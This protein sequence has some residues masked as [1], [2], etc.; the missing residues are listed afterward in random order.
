LRPKNILLGKGCVKIADFGM[1][2]P[3]NN[4]NVKL[5]LMQFISSRYY[6]APEGLVPNNVYTSAVDVWAVGCIMAEMILG[7]V[8]FKDARCLDQMKVVVNTLGHFT[9]EDM[10]SIAHGINEKF[11]V[12]LRTLQPTSNKQLKDFFPDLDE[13]GFDLLSQMLTF[14]PTKRIT[15]EKALQHA[16]FV[17][18]VQTSN[19]HQNV[20]A[21]SQP[22]SHNQIPTQ[23]ET[24]NE[25][26]MDDPETK[27]ETETET[28]TEL[29]TEFNGDDIENVSSLDDIRELLWKE[30]EALHCQDKKIN[31]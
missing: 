27:N 8:F 19:F 4:K 12:Y 30:V 20:I 14:N 21:N 28:E 29:P 31:E 23:S 6:T 24:E 11:K 5:S 16:W 1:G 26:E 18:D 3:T 2:R 25:I 7:Q 10:D 13:N 9:E 22:Q 15:V 17:D